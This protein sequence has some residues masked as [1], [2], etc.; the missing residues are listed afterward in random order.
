MVRER[1]EE[2]KIALFA[3]DDMRAAV[4]LVIN[5]GMSL[6]KAAQ[7]RNVNYGTLSR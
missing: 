5:Q 2:K 3:E 1:K 7:A 4:E 6:R